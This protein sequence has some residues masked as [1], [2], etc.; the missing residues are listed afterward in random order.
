MA[1]VER[2]GIS[3]DKKL[4]G[5]FD[6]M[7]E[8]L[9]YQNRSEAVRDMIRDKL[10]AKKLENPE[11]TAV[12][13]VC[14]VYDH[15]ETALSKRLLELQHSKHLQTISTMHIHVD[16]HNCLEI[17]ALRGKVRD[18]TQTADKIISLRGVKLGKVN[19]IATEDSHTHSH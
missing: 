6:K 19:M 18:I 16:H 9:G 3:L 1:Q 5:Q 10:E 11:T 2:I 8:Q 4:L 17:I 12:A 13:A 14:L 7:I 15:H